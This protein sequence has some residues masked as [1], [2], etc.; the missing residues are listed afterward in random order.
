MPV[1]QA[2]AIAAKP[3]TGQPEFLVITAKQQPSQWI[4]PKGHV[5]PGEGLDQA[6]LRELR[7]ETGVEGTLVGKVGSSR[8]V[9]GDEDVEVTYFLV[10]ARSDGASREGRGL[11]WLRYEAARVQ[12]SFD[13]ARALLDK[14][15]HMLE[16][17]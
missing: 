3:H 4:F 5:E 8:F 10:L 11:R 17:R 13:D 1:P 2:G 7:E 6:A 14:A 9:S 12:L 16:A 15:L